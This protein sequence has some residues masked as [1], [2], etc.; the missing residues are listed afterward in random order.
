MTQ[1]F[2]EKVKKY[3]PRFMKDLDLTKEQVSGMFG[4]FYAETGGFKLLQ[5]QKPL[6]KGSRGGYGWAQWTGPRRKAYENWAKTNNLDVSD[7]ET[8][9]KYIVYELKGGP[10]SEAL[11]L[12]K[13]TK[14]PKA[15][16]E[17]FCAKYERPGIPHM[18]VRVQWAE[19]ANELLSAP[20]P[21]TTAGAGAAA[22]AA[23]AVGV[24]HAAGLGW[25]EILGLAILLVTFVGGLTYLIHKGSEQVYVDQH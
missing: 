16:A 20:T 3:G 12:L 25:M 13:L 15:A 6:V 2:N 17:T 1:L 22:G 10:E 14:T 4:N 7:D 18:D 11:R 21:K 24:G 23:V 5:E 19:R 8:N 9:Y